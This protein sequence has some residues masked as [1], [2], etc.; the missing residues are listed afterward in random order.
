MPSIGAAE[1][2]I[3]LVIALLVFGP[4]RLP[5]MGRSIG[6]SVREFKKA[7][8][9]ARSEFGVDEIEREIKGVKKSIN[10]VRGDLKVDLD[11]ETAK[12]S[13]AAA[14]AGAATAAAGG[15]AEAVT[16]D[17]GNADETQTA[18]GAP[19]AASASPDAVPDGAPPDDDADEVLVGDVVDD[20]ADDRQAQPVASDGQRP[21]TD[22]RPRGD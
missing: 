6:R 19:Q 4:K 20:E 16:A 2:V 3:I 13:T 22:T 5:E 12:P 9:Q 8:D 1:I 21:A 14:A 15:T 17:A 10:D 18:N 7:A 11:A